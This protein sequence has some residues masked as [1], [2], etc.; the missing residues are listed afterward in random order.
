MKISQAEA[1]RLKRRVEELEHARDAAFARWG[2]DYPGG[3][4][5]ATLTVPDVAAAKI[6]TARLLDHAVMA[7]QDGN[8]VYFYALPQSSWSKK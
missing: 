7:R 6:A 8:T 3:T 2:R 5:I 4:H 1:R